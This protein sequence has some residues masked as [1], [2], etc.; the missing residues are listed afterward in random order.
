MHT[1]FCCYICFTVDCFIVDCF[2]VDCR[3][4]IGAWDKPHGGVAA[5]V[6]WHR[7][8]GG[9]P[10]VCRKKRLRVTLGPNPR[11]SDACPPPTTGRRG[12]RWP[13]RVRPHAATRRGHVPPASR[14]ARADAGDNVSTCDDAITTPPRVIAALP[15][16]GVSSLTPRPCRRLPRGPIPVRTARACSPR[17]RSPTPRAAGRASWPAAR[18]HS[19]T[20]RQPPRPL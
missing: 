11:K 17:S 6:E 4:A 20:R 8:G 12:A 7:E 1:S 3:P 19:T 16:D 10:A 5:A 14:P 2:T 13:Q 18:R 15:H 9:K